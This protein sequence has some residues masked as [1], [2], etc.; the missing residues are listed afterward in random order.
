[1]ARG[2]K[3]PRNSDSSAFQEAVDAS[4]DLDGTG[5]VMDE[6]GPVRMVKLSAE[7]EAKAGRELASKNIEL[8]ALEL[9]KKLTADNF[10]KKVKALKKAIAELSD[11]TAAGVRPEPTQATLPGTV[12]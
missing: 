8:R 6:D 3:Q 7:E 9:E 5:V 4:A 2:K 12:Q 11:D 10:R 1:M